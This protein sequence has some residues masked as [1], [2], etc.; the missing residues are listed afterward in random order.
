MTGQTARSKITISLSILCERGCYGKMQNEVDNLT[1]TIQQEID[2]LESVEENRKIIRIC[3]GKWLHKLQNN[4]INLSSVQDL[5]V[6]LELDRWL[7][8][9]G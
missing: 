8:Q 6:I 3:L 2:K 7:Q 9:N 1:Q 4:E 5:K